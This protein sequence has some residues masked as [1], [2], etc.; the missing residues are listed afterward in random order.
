MQ[1]QQHILRDYAKMMEGNLGEFALNIAGKMD[2]NAFFPTPKV[3]PKQLTDKANEYIAALANCVDGTSADTAHKN[4]VKAELIALLDTLADDVEFTAQGNQEMLASTGYDLTNPTAV[5]PAPVGTVTITNVNNVATTKLG[6]DLN[7]QGNVWAVLVQTMTAPNVWVTAAVF[8]DLKNA[9]V[10]N[11][12]PG[13][14]YT[15]RAC[16]MAASNQQSEWCEPV[17]HMST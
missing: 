2:G 12:V 5:S 15:F 17:S 4:K 8:T 7:V 6:L 1:K 11:L 10:P 14:V 3:T 16:A 13:T 9:V